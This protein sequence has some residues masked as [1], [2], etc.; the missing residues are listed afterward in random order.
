MLSVDGGNRL[1]M[2]RKIEL[3]ESIFVL[4]VAMYLRIASEE[5]IH[6]FT[7]SFSTC[8]VLGLSALFL[9]VTHYCGWIDAVIESIEPILGLEPIVVPKHVDTWLVEVETVL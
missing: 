4:V 5:F 8:L 6:G 9:L 3:C 2:S 7:V 1:S